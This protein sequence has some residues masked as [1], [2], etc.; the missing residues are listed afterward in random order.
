MGGLI[1]NW[2][3]TDITGLWLLLKRQGNQLGGLSAPR[4]LRMVGKELSDTRL[5]C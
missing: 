4:F 2:P 3:V 1:A 5:I